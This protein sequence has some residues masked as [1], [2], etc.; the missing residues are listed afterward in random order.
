MQV[1]VVHGLVGVVF[2]ADGVL[3]VVCVDTHCLAGP[4]AQQAAITLLRTLAPVYTAH[5]ATVCCSSLQVSSRLVCWTHVA[6]C[7]WQEM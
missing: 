1:Q 3:T 5:P 2:C 4:P 7:L 6:W